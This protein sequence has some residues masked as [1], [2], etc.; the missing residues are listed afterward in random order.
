MGRRQLGSGSRGGPE[1]GKSLSAEVELAT[2]KVVKQLEPRK[3]VAGL[4]EI[5]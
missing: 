2:L 4:S 5:R 1:G 3:F